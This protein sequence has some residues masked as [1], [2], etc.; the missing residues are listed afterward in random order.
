MVRAIQSL[1]TIAQDHFEEVDDG[2]WLNKLQELAS[3][4]DR[5]AKLSG[6]A[7]AILL[8]EMKYRMSV[9]RRKFRVACHQ[10]F[11]LIWERDGSKA[12]R[13]ATDTR[14]CLGYRCGSS[15]IVISD[16][17]KKKPSNVHL[18]FCASFRFI[19]TEGEGVGGRDD[20]RYLG[21]WR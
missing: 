2:L 8:D 6:F 4:D 18:C 17:W 9:L 10:G 12:C 7:F 11:P 13:C 15:L 14:C 20:G 3:R 1:H 16:R 19:R 21:R 5:N